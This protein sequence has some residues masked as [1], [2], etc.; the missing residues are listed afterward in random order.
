[1]LYNDQDILEGAVAILAKPHRQ[2]EITGLVEAR[3]L[4][5]EIAPSRAV[6]TRALSQIETAHE[7]MS[8]M[9]GPGDFAFQHAGLC[10]TCLPHRRPASNSAIWKRKSG[11]FTLYVRPGANIEGQDEHAAE[12][13]DYV[14]VPYGA[15]ARLILIYLQT[16]GLKSR[17]VHLGDNLSAFL[18][19]LG[20]PRSGGPRGAIGQVKEQFTRI[21]GSTF[22][23]KWDNGSGV[24]DISNTQIVDGARLWNISSSDWS[25]T[26]DLSEKFHQHLREHAVILDK[27]AVA[28][29]QH[30]SMGLDLYSLFA[31][32]LPRLNRELRLTWEVLQ[33][34]IGSEYAQMRDLARQVRVVMPEVMIA[35]PH[36]NVDVTVSGLLLKPSKASVPP[37]TQVHGMSILSGGD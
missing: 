2:L 8:E 33:S 17:V 20:V 5:T 30:N 31:Y 28:H 22:T 21:A 6:A 1:V 36:A 19:S 4:A 12:E 32:R 23:L 26:V 34:Q 18:R 24:T 13:E 10:Q 11:Y 16:E 9:P 37:R 29:L 7:I 14:G 3:R 25:A 15:K 27:R 35:Y